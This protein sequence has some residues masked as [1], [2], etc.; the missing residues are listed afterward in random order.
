MVASSAGGSLMTESMQWQQLDAERVLSHVFEF[1]PHGVALC[2]SD[3]RIVLANAELERM[4]GYTRAELR[5]LTVEQLVPMRFRAAHSLLRANEP[6][7]PRS[8]AMGAG[9]ELCG[10]RA[11]GSEFPIEVGVSSLQTPSRLLAIETMVDISERK[12]LERMFQKMVESA[13]CAMIMIDARGRVAL[14][15][16]Q[17]E[18]MF[19]YSRSEIIGNT[20]EMLLPERLREAHQAH[21]EAFGQAPA[22]R[23]MGAGRDLTARHKDG[24][25]FP[26]EIGLNPVPGEESGFVLAA[27]TDITRR[28]SMERALQRAHADLEE[29][30]SA[31]SHDLKS[32]LRGIADLVDWIAEDLAASKTSEVTHN[33]GRVKERV[34]R[35]ERVVEDLLTYARSG[36]SCSEAVLIELPNLIENVLEVQSPPS[37]FRIE[38]SIEATPFVTVRTPLETVLRNLIGNA[39]QHHHREQGRIGIRVEDAG[40]FCVFTISDDGPGIPVAARERVFRIF[41]TLSPPGNA[42]SGIG[43]ALSK[44]L[45]ESHGGRIAIE[46]GE[47]GCGTSVRVWWPRFART[48]ARE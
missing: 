29:F 46:S 45:V 20:L 11:D 43:L 15:N 32:P 12:R 14:M 35:L 37:G 17:T 22:M 16:P 28:K 5:L 48:A 18:Q 24:T 7:D 4:F 38:R 34:C 33:L 1:A 40:E 47:G 21:R 27:V 10:E 13:P 31:A 19:G 26:V 3:G 9:R 42:G 6:S 8:H 36:P 44:R 25:E 41:Q 23:R 2:E 39:V 30:T